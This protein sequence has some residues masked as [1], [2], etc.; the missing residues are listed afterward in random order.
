M[1]FRNL[2]IY[3]RVKLHMK[4]VVEW[5]HITNLNNSCSPSFYFFFWKKEN[6]ICHFYNNPI[7]STSLLEYRIYCYHSESNYV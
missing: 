7:R 3:S 1:F 2:C 5:V 6:R 4:N